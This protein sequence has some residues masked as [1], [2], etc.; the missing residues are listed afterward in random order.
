MGV[1]ELRARTVSGIDTGPPGTEAAATD[2]AGAVACGAAIAVLRLAAA[3]IP[4]AKATK[5]ATDFH[6]ISMKFFT[7][8]CCGLESYR[9]LAK[10]VIWRGIYGA[11]GR[12]VQYLAKKALGSERVQ[13]GLIRIASW[14][15]AS[16]R[17]TA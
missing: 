17:R 11:K 5:R 2:F 14:F 7:W 16:R 1:G 3:I 6:R 9:R 12:G 15:V 10:T 8:T 13:S 4:R